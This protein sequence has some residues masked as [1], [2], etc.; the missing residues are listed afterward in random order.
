[1]LIQ[2]EGV[3][4]IPHTFLP[5]CLLLIDARRQ[6]TVHLHSSLICAVASK[7]SLKT[8][9]THPDYVHDVSSNFLDVTQH[10]V[11][12]EWAVK[13]ISDWATHIR[14]V[15]PHHSSCCCWNVS[16]CGNEMRLDTPESRVGVV[17]CNGLFVLES[18]STIFRGLDTRNQRRL[19]F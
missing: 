13:I 9:L 2:S 5:V 3:N 10:H 19:R 11:M 7:Y 18:L 16:G 4:S 8:V 15:D 14:F 1:M 12:R 6:F 17:S